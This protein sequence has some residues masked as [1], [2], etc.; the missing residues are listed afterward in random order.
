MRHVFV[1]VFAPM[2]WSDSSLLWVDAMGEKR[3]VVRNG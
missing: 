3:S 2:D 1:F